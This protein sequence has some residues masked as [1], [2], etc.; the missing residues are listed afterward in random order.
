MKD[1]ID[2]LIDLS[3]HTALNRLPVLLIDLALFKPA[4]WV[5]LVQLF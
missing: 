5:I 1:S 3:G 4:G 2:V